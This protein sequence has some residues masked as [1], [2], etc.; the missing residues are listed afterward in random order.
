MERAIW[1]KYRFQKIQETHN[2]SDCFCWNV[3]KRVE[4]LIISYSKEVLSFLKVLLVSQLVERRY[5]EGVGA[6]TEL[7]GGILYLFLWINLHFCSAL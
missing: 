6:L 2:R 7:E 3:V 1:H 5:P 4:L